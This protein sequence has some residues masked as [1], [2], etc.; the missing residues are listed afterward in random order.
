MP[1]FQK[2]LEQLVIKH[3]QS[4]KG[5]QFVRIKNYI[6][7]AYLKITCEETNRNAKLI[8]NENKVIKRYLI[9]IF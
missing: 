9:I 5:G 6:S 8:E 3:H 4:V 7:N 1:M 2:H